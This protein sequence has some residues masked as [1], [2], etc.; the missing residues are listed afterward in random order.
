MTEDPEVLAARLNLETGRIGWPEL[1]RHFARGHLVR[2]A[3]DLDLVEAATALARDDGD[4]VRDWMA[5][6]RMA[7][8]DADDARRWQAAGQQFWAVVVTPWVLVQEAS[9]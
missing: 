8:A 1:E 5:A 4:S 3:P 2:V 9:A 7:P 6:G